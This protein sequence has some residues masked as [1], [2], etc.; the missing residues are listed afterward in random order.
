[1]P[2]SKL[3][4]VQ[5]KA[6]AKAA[7][8]LNAKRRAR[9]A[10]KSSAKAAA[11][12]SGRREV[13][14]NRKPTAAEKLA[15]RDIESYAD[16]HH[17]PGPSKY[18]AT[19]PVQ[20]REMARLG[21][22]DSDIAAFFEVHL[23]TI[24]KWAVAHPEFAEAL[25]VGK[26]E[27][28]DRVE[29]SLYHRANGYTFEAEKILVVNKAVERVA[30]TEHLPPDINACIFWLKNRRPELWR[31]QSHQIHDGKI[32]H[33]HSARDEIARR[34]ISIEAR[35]RAAADPQQPESGAAEGSPARLALLGPPETTP[36][37]G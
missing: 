29:R 5:L 21:A 17:G 9:S 19:F 34:L 6:K 24:R 30:Y 12:S 10:A 20:A 26:T 27:A 25:K 1:M 28:D 33:E 37:D 2:A 16:A 3:T 7:A 31:E 13:T 22:T 14:P 11:K 18:R 15:A 35:E 8:A 32:E 36:A 23:V 4:K